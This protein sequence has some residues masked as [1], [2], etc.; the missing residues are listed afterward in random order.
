MSIADIAEIVYEATRAAKL[1]YRQEDAQRMPEW[2]ALPQEKRDAH[3]ELTCRILSNYARG[4][5]NP[6]GLATTLVGLLR[7]VN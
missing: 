7:E 5:D 1:E 6:A 3:I 2:H 4:I